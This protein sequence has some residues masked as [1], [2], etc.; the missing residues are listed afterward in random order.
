MRCM[1]KLPCGA[2]GRGCCDRPAAEERG[3]GA[4]C[5][6]VHAVTRLPTEAGAPGVA[7]CRPCALAAPPAGPT[8]EMDRN[9]DPRNPTCFAP[10]VM[11][12]WAMGHRI[13]EAPGAGSRGSL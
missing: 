10:S 13:L 8:P 12:V 9:R 1:A 4:Q 6:D 5:P 11:S 2:C 3:G 7:S